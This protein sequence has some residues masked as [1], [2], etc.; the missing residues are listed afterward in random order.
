LA[1]AFV[2]RGNDAPVEPEKIEELA[3]LVM[4]LRGVA[5]S[6][7]PVECIAVPPAFPL[8]SHIARLDEVGDDALRRPLR[9]SHG[10]CDVAETDIG[11]ALDAKKHLRMAREKVPVL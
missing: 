10:V 5:H 6:H 2:L 3:D 8:S 11:A 1:A 9:D 7:T 4:H